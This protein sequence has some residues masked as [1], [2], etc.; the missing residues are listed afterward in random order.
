MIV[1]MIDLAATDIAVTSPRHHGIS[2]ALHIKGRFRM[3]TIDCLRILIFRIKPTDVLAAAG[4]VAVCV[5]FAVG[6]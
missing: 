6:H 5:I 2:F 1:I 3:N 4:M